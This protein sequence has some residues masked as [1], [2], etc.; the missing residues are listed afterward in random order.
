LVVLARW[1][2]TGDVKHVSAGVSLYMGSSDEDIRAFP[3]PIFAAKEKNHVRPP[4]FP[5]H[6]RAMEIV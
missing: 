2:K 4:Y 3:F 1:P 5:T 6:G